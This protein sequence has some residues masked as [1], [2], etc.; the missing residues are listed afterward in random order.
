MRAQQIRNDKRAWR[1]VRHTAEECG[2]RDAMRTYRSSSG[3]TSSNTVWGQSGRRRRACTLTSVRRS[4]CTCGFPAYSFHEDS[5]FRDAGPGINGA[6]FTTWSMNEWSC[7]APVGLIQ[8][9]NLLGRECTGIS[10][11]ELIHPPALAH[12]SPLSSQP[13]S[14]AA[15]PNPSQSPVARSRG[16]RRASGTTQPSVY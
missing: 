13:P 11:M 9:T 3:Q 7:S 5:F 1:L 15:F 2:I 14:P 10:L 12:W 6:R 16:F 8:S 4:N